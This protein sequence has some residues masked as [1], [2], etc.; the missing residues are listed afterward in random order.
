MHEEAMENNY[1]VIRMQFCSF[2]CIVFITNLELC[3]GGLPPHTFFPC[4]W[5]ALFKEKGI[6]CF[7][8]FLF[9]SDSEPVICI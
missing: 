6:S 8:F 3:F 7:V 5:C 2:V 9:G 4:I 1:S